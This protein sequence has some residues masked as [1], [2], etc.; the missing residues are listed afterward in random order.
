M[1]EEIGEN[2]RDKIKILYAVYGVGEFIEGVEN[3]RDDYLIY[4]FDQNYDL[5][6]IQSPFD[7]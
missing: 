5:I 1:S 2:I 4:I 7:I 6:K 3:I